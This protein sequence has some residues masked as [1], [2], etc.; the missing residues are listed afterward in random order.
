MTMMKYLLQDPVQETISEDAVNFHSVRYLRWCL[1]SKDLVGATLFFPEPYLFLHERLVH[2]VLY[3][4]D[5]DLSQD[6]SWNW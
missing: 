2:R 6:F 5:D 1:K 4:L 3:P